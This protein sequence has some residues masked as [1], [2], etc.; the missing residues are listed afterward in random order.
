MRKLDT[1]FVHCSATQPTGWFAGLT[2]SDQVAEIDRWHKER[3]WKGFGYHI[4]IDRSGQVREG[5]PVTQ[6]GA[7]VLGH[8]EHSIH[9]CL[10]GGFG[11]R[12][13]DDPSDNFTAVQLTELRLMIGRLKDQFGQHLKVRGHNE[14]SNKA[15]P[16]FNVK[17][18]YHGKKPAP[19]VP[20]K[21]IEKLT[22]A[23]PIGTTGGLG[24]G[25]LVSAFGGWDSHAQIVL[26]GVVAVV[27]AVAVIKWVIYE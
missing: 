21:T 18:W 26:A 3:G 19:S 15:C 24:V 23:A 16:G 10:A 20:E 12:A 8:N 22:K 4:Y 17:K 25:A 14:V 2:C 7:G 11:S 5:R 6:V 27:V 1:I 13:D 9:V